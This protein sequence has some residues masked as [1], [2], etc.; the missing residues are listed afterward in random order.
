MRPR[1][2]APAGS[3]SSEFGRAEADGTVSVLEGEQWRVV[4][5]YPDGTPAEALAYFRRKFDDLEFKVRNLEQR[6]AGGGAAAS[7]LTGQS[8]HLLGE[9][10]GADA[11]GD[12]LGLAGR[13][14]ALIAA[15]S[16]AS[17]EEAKA[18]REAVAQAIAD[19]TVVVEKAEALAARDPQTVQWKQTSADLSALFDEW[20][21][22]QANGPRLPKNTAQELWKRFRTARSTVE[23]HRREFFAKLDE[24]HKSARDGKTKLVERAEALVARGE[25]G[26]P[27]YRA[28]LDE[29][30]NAG[31]AG[32]KVDDALWAR[33][34]AAGDALYGARTERDA[35]EQAESQPRIEARQA[36]LV[37]AKA[38]ADESDLRKARQLLTGIQRRWDEVGRIFPRDKERQLDDEMRRI[39]QALRARED[40]DWKKNDPETQARADGMNRQLL[41]AIDK[42]ESEVAAAEAAGNA[43]K[44]AEARE[45]L[46]ARRAW[47][48]AIGG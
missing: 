47:L 22:Q 23:K 39:E 3:D 27:A 6:H 7:E 38:V 16:E 9:V 21:A 14:E 29:W 12:L 31:R 20:Q 37:E 30:K 28:L 15:L 43:K 13:L 8:R 17:A 19:R 5:Q 32:R 4:G 34:K 36:L 2:V 35:A 11:V 41:D 26:I 48:K 46:E 42:L 44:A 24:T 33:F 18:Q 1:P 40:V 45:A 10:R 25:E